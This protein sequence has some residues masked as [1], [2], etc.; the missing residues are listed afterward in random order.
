MLV[1]VLSFS[2]LM[3]AECGQCLQEIGLPRKDALLEW[4]RRRLDRL[5][6]DHLLRRGYLASALHLAR[7]SNI[8]VLGKLILCKVCCGLRTHV[9]NSIS[10]LQN[11][12]GWKLAWICVAR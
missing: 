4:N 2:Q 3:S 10:C 5:L 1:P 11:S 7:D 6:V 12:K 9:M 8:Q